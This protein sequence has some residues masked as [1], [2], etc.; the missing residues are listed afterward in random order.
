MDDL[1][2]QTWNGYI[3]SKPHAQFLQSWEWGEFQESL[4][5][6]VHRAAC[7]SVRGE[8]MDCALFLE[9]PLFSGSTYAYFPR[10]PVECFSDALLG[11]VQKICTK[12]L[13]RTPLFL[14]YEPIGIDNNSITCARRGRRVLSVQPEREWLLD[15]S[16]GESEIFSQ[17]HPKTRYNIR[18]ASKKNVQVRRVDHTEDALERSIGILYGFLEKTAHSKEYR[19]H[20]RSYYHSLITFFTQHINKD[21]VRDVPV[22]RLFEATVESIAVASGCMMYF[23]DTVYYL[24]GGSNPKCSALMAPYALHAHAIRDAIEAGYRY[25]NFG[26]ISPEGADRHSLAGVTR[27]KMGFGGE[28]ILYPGTFD[29]VL[30]NVGY[31][32]YQ[33]GRPLWRMFNRT[34]KS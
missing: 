29:I 19:L 16:K 14:R 27:F 7:R 8:S 6:P 2:R 31:M 28:H 22:I 3:A 24:Y 17:M 30:N 34:R 32:V 12:Q 33:I 15:L 11:E 25:Y 21:L 10:G 20:G 1:N 13:K 23:G 5:F 26:G 18:L 9:L 4:G